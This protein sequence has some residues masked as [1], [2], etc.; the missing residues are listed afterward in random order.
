MA[1]VLERL[2]SL[3]SIVKDRDLKIDQ[4]N[5][6]VESLERLIQGD[7]PDG[8]DEPDGEEDDEVAY[9]VRCVRSAFT[10]RFKKKI[11]PLYLGEGTEDEVVWVEYIEDAKCFD[12]TQ[13]AAALALAKEYPIRS[14]GK[15]EY[16]QPHFI[17]R[18]R[19][20]AD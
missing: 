19:S 7:V 10:E 14:K 5:D 2:L 16:G 20:H 8:D 17:L 12:E 13:K 1:N 9:V 6:R 4:L 3:E 18:E 15:G 11:P